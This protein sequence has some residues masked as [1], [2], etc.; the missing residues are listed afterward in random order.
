MKQRPAAALIA[1]ALGIALTFVMLIVLTLASVHERTLVALSGSFIAPTAGLLIA[2]WKKPE[3]FLS[4][5]S[6]LW[7]WLNA[8]LIHS[9]QRATFLVSVFASIPWLMMRVVGEAFETSNF[10]SYAQSAYYPLAN[11]VVD[12]KGWGYEPLWY[13]WLMLLAL[14]GCVFAIFGQRVAK[15]LLRWIGGERP[16]SDA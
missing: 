4:A 6:R 9:V 1:L 14:L 16:P 10:T 7:S 11:T 2:G 8:R 3:M 5:I 15:P 12:L 13:D